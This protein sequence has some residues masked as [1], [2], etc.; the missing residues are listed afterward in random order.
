MQCCMNSVLINNVP[1]ET[2]HVQLENPFNATH[3]IIIPLKLNGVTCFFEVRTPTLEEYESQN[4]LKIELMVEAPPWDLSNPE[5]Q[6]RTEDARFQGTFCQPKHSSK[7]T[8]I[9]QLCH[10]IFL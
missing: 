8:I 3:P 6:V 10:I 7:W 9:H 1:N 4:I 5:L 2:I